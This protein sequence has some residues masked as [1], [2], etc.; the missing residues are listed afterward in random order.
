MKGFFTLG[1][2]KSPQKL[3]IVKVIIND[4][5]L[6]K[7]S[8]HTYFISV[9]TKQ[10][11][12]GNNYYDYT[13][14]TITCYTLLKPDY[15]EDYNPQITNYLQTLIFA[16][17]AIGH[18]QYSLQNDLI[19]NITQEHFVQMFTLSDYPLHSLVNFGD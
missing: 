16:N 7:Y 6:K 5:E 17:T 12:I 8:N 14:N 15:Y 4:N 13:S 11:Q 2:N 19:P 1:Q 3:P 9:G 10:I 18:Y